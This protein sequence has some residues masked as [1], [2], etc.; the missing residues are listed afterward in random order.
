MNTVTK[1]QLLKITSFSLGHRK[2]NEM[3]QTDGINLDFEIQRHCRSEGN[4]CNH[5]GKS[6]DRIFSITDTSGSVERS[7]K[8]S[9]LIYSI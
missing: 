6:I 1:Y 9:V 2:E 8:L 3:A 5:I 4:C 7:P